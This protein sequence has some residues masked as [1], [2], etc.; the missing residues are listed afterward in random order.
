MRSNKKILFSLG[1]HEN[2]VQFIDFQAELKLLFM[3]YCPRGSLY[4]I[5]HVQGQSGRR[6]AKNSASDPHV[7]FIKHRTNIIKDTINGNIILFLII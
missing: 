1:K 5:L 6:K 4:D 7:E 2:I 3:E